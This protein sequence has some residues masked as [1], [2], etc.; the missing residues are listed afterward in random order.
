VV[1]KSGAIYSRRMMFSR[2]ITCIAQ[3]IAFS[4]EGMCGCGQ[5]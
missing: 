3:R 4:K 2:E 5:C 1:E